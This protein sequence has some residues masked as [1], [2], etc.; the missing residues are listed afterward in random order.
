MKKNTVHCIYLGM[1]VLPMFRMMPSVTMTMMSVTTMM[2]MM[3]LVMSMAMIL[4]LTQV[5]RGSFMAFPKSFDYIRHLSA[6]YQKDGNHYNE[7][8]FVHTSIQMLFLSGL[9]KVQ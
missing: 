2:T 7:G 3:L 9:Q 5:L 6:H 8:C 4:L 1:M